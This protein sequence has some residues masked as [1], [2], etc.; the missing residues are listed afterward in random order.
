MHY[1]LSIFQVVEIIG[2]R[3]KTICMPPNIFMGVGAAAS[4]PPPTRIDASDS[5]NLNIKHS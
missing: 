5:N 1:I 3:G 2:G 4:L